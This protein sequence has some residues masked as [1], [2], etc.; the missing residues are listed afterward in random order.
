MLLRLTMLCLMLVSVGCSSGGGRAGDAN[1]PAKTSDESAMK[2]ET[3]FIGDA[4]NS[5]K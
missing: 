5:K 4:K 1:D 3:G 2:D